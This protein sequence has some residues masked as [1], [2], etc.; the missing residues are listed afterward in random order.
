MSLPYKDVLIP[1]AK[2]LRK[3]AT[4]QENHLWY[5]YLRTYPIRFQRLNWMAPNIILR[6]VGFTIKRGVWSLPDL[7]YRCSD[8]QMRKLMGSFQRSVK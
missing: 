5:D 8:F 2:E 7:A 3:N 6:M 4:K 1:K